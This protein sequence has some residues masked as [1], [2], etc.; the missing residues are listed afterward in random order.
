M[1]TPYTS[2]RPRMRIRAVTDIG[3]QSTADRPGPEVSRIIADAEPKQGARKREPNKGS[4]QH[5]QSGNPAGRPRGA[6]GVKAMVRKAFDTRIEIKS[7]KGPKKVRIF[8]ALLKKEVSLAAE[9]D[10]RARKTVFDLGKWALGDSIELPLTPEASSPEQLTE[11]GQA[12]IAWFK[13]EITEQS[14]NQ[15]DGQ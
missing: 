9:G 8:E 14:R 10:W 1:D 2:P 5:G 4:F 7:A 15:G 13:D 3:L 12:I 6:K 11:T